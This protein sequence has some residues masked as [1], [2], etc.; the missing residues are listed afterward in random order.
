M[1]G[2]IERRV[3]ERR[4]QDHGNEIVC[5]GCHRKD[6]HAQNDDGMYHDGRRADR[7]APVAPPEE[8]T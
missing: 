7:R 2:R 4:I 6:G 8:T 5:F 3:A 1:S